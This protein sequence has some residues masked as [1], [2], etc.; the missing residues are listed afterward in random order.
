MNKPRT[1]FT[2]I[3]L[4]IV[5][6]I[7]GVLIAI[8][9]PSLRG[10]QRR[11]KKVK[12]VTLISHVGK[13]WSMYSVDH[14]DKILPGY[15]NPDVQEKEKLAWAFPDESLVPPAPDYGTSLP[16]DAGPWTFR[17]LDYFDYDWKSLM[18]YRELE[19]SSGELREHADVIATEPAFGYNGFYLGGW[20]IID[21]HSNRVM[22]LFNSVAI[23]DGEQT[24]VVT[25]NIS[26]IPRASHQIVFCSTFFAS[27][28]IHI[29]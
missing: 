6:S 1:A 15:I 28:G 7:I 12:E 3:E 5:I 14:R 26:A 17:L 22:P 10:V 9:L 27:H 19:W 21:N 4:I 18:F 11:A 25:T 8:L 23:A 2:I 24:N 20:Q 13:A 16:N 29:D